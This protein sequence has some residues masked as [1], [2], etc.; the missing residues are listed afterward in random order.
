MTDNKTKLV[1]VDTT[2]VP[3]TLNEVLDKYNAEID[4]ML[5]QHRL[6]RDIEGEEDQFIL[7]DIYITKLREG[8]VMG[9][10]ILQEIRKK[11]PE[12]INV[13]YKPEETDV[14]TD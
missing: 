10:L 5:D 4:F 12:V 1:A 3:K 8:I 9:E 7:L 2:I 14:V 6:R 11:H 13:L